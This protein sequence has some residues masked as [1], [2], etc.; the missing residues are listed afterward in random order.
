MTNGTSQGYQGNRDPENKEK[1]FPEATSKNA[2]ILLK[3]KVNK[4]GGFNQTTKKRKGHLLGD[5]VF[6]MCSYYLFFQT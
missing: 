6:I 2:N 3:K 1:L 4:C 5:N